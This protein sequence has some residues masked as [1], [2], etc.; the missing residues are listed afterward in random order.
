[1]KM[2]AFSQIKL[3]H[4]FIS[5]IATAPIISRSWCVEGA[6]LSALLR[7]TAIWQA[8]L[9]APT[10]NPK[11][12]VDKRPPN[13]VLIVADDLGFNDLTFHGGGVAGGAVPTPHID[14]IARDGVTLTKGYAGAAMCSPSRAA[15]LTGRYASRFGFELTPTHPTVEKVIGTFESPQTVHRPI[16]F[17]DRLKEMPPADKI[18]MP[19]SEITIA[20][21]LKPRGYHSILLGKWHL[22]SGPGMTPIEQGFD[23]SLGFLIGASMYKPKTDSEV[24]NSFQ[25]FDPVDAL[26]W[27]AHPFGVS[28]NNGPSFKPATYMTDYLGD[29]AAKALTANKNRPFFLY[30]AFN[31]P[32]TP[33]QALKSDFDALTSIKDHRLRVYAAM[34]RA[35]D[36][37]VGK[38]LQ[39]LRANGLEE[40]TL[41]IFTSDNGGADYIG[42]PDINKPYR[43]WKSTFFEGGI[44]VP[45]LIK[46]PLSLRKGMKYDQTVG[47]VDIFA[48]VAGAAD[49]PLP[50]DRLI[51]GVDVIP[52][53]KGK[54][55][56]SPHESLFWRACDYKVLLAENWK[57]QV[58]A[59]PNK[60]W[61]F[62][63]KGDPTEKVNLAS[64]RPDKV[65]EMMRVLENINRKQAKPIW[66]AMSEHA[67]TIDHPLGFPNKKTDE[68]VYWP[69]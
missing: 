68:H 8:S 22:G 51:D 2:Q 24:V 36:R 20:E 16:Y 67:V 10:R 7:T 57:L 42:L 45:F 41:V 31:A 60:V 6:N 1:M 15:M 49:A 3:V 66:P 38:V 14:S 54:V 35:L 59:R 29:E 62:N 19:S 21:V 44:H 17:A 30:L 48:T 23:E 69:N 43:G 55:Q 50:S 56:G 5:L 34:I 46:W 18:G 26:V 37:N 63:L 61:L 64:K 25:E 40:N 33:L 9:D 27:G 12:P 39:T 32:H 58:S 11:H 4:L 52:F 47:Q 13:I 28:F 65:A 53:L